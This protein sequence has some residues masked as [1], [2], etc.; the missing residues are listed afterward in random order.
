MPTTEASWA[1]R[2]ETPNMHT[3]LCDDEPH[4]RHGCSIRSIARRIDDALEQARS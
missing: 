3:A 4:D 2:P 1:S